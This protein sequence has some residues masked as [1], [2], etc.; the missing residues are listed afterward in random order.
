M[1]ALL[2]PS[3]G[4]MVWASIAF[5][6]VLIILRRAAWGPILKG[7]KDREESIASS[8][9]EAEK[10]RDEIANLKSDNEKLLQEARNERDAILREAREMKDQ[11][12]AD[13][14]SQAKVEAEK[15]INSAREAVQNEK[16]AALAELKSHVASLSLEIA[17]KVVRQKL[18]DDASQK[19][20]VDQ[21]LKETDLN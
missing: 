19:E 4:T 21:L 9:N 1:D 15:M 17:E 16:A 2:S 11:M 10:A 6:I 7:L 13:A 5:I 12:V 8:L 3:L 14:K 20:L 18:A